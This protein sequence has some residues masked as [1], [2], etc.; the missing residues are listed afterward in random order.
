MKWFLVAAIISSHYGFATESEWKEVNKIHIDCAEEYCFC[1]LAG[2]AYKEAK[3]TINGKEFWANDS[4]GTLCC[5]LG[6]RIREQL[7][8]N[9]I[10]SKGIVTFCR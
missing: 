8:K 3:A 9:G 7:C 6:C 10:D 1:T 4:E 2:K 5:H